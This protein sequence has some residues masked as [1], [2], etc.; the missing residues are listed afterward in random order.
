MM[1]VNRYPLDSLFS[2]SL[3]PCPKGESGPPAVLTPGIPATLLPLLLSHPAP[4]GV[5]HPLGGPPEGARQP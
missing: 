4:E 5:H 1:R 3:S 2:L